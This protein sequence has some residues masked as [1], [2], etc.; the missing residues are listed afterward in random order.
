MAF[1]P[2]EDSF[3][4]N[5]IVLLLKPFETLEGTFEANT[6]VTLKGEGINKLWNFED[7]SGHIAQNCD[8][9]FFKK[10]KQRPITCDAYYR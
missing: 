5:E 10:I 1:I 6:V 4:N 2:K 9:S 3:K 8:K 7:E